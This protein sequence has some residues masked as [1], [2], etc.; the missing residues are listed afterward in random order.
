MAITHRTFVLLYRLIAVALIFTG[1]AR[2]LGFGSTF[3]PSA[4][5]YYTVLSNTLCL[6]WLVVQLVKMRSRPSV[7]AYWAPRFGA[8]IMMAITV[9]MLVYLVILA[10][11]NFDQAGNYQAFTLTDSLVHIITPVLFI[12]DW[13][14]FAP[15]GTLPWFAPLTWC[16]IPLLY[17]AFALT[18]SVSG[19]R[20]GENKVPYPFL[21]YEELGVGGVFVQV[22]ILVVVFVALGY[23]YVA[24]DRAFARL[25]RRNIQAPG[26]T[27]EHLA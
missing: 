5:L 17:L 22:L 21:D 11:D 9:T 24:L 6:V 8:A 19:V 14:A 18:A 10:P 3:S 7:H 12:V 2:I 20:F 15:K 16:I 1:L 25:N 13:F 26:R 4:L 27:P 23:V